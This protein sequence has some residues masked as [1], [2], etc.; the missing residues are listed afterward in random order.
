MARTPDEDRHDVRG[1]LG[2]VLFIA[3]GLIG[4]W[5]LRDVPD[6]PAV[7]FP[8][9]V[10]GLMMAFS[11]LLIVRNLVGLA[12]PE[13]RA[14]PGSVSRRVGLIVAMVLGTLAMPFIGFV[15]AGLVSYL[16]I[17][18]VAMYER[19]TWSRCAVY[20]LAGFIVVLGFYFV[21]QGFFQVPLPDASLFVL[22]F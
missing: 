14:A 18:S 1:T 5:D 3:V 15:L 10:L 8:H 2:G 17:M 12:S 19:W 21:F 4:W 6:G 20:P 22:P 9:T 11:G 7:V 13:S 16:A